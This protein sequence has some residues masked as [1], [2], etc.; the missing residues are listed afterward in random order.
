MHWLCGSFD[1]I[2]FSWQGLRRWMPT[3]AR[4]VRAKISPD[5]DFL[6]VVDSSFT[7]HDYALVADTA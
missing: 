3:L 7:A 6:V 4:A 2:A 1:V 5:A